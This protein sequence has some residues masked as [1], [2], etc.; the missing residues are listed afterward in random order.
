MHGVAPRVV[1]GDSWWNKTRQAAYSS[2]NFCCVACGVHKSVA[3]YRQWLEGHE[4][5]DIDYGA[6]RM[7]YVE[8]IPLCHL[9]HNYIHSGRLAALL[10]KGKITHAKFKAVMQ[11]GEQIVE[12]IPQEIS[13]K[14][15]NSQQQSIRKFQRTNPPWHSWRMEV[16]GV[17]HPPKYS[18]FQEW[19]I[20]HGQF[21]D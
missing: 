3:K 19:K 21:S 4:L 9:C 5:Y 2:T 16:D 14:I 20:A 7:V 12:A 6:A 15:L 8:T 10:S 11:H 18:S 17:L 1:L 13:R